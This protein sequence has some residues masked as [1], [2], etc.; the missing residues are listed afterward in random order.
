V[1][2]IVGVVV[3]IVGVVV[4]IVGVVVGVVVTI[5]GVVVGVV[6]TILGVVVTMVGVV[7]IG[8]KIN[9]NVILLLQEKKSKYF[10]IHKK[11]NTLELTYLVV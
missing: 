3:T 7:S 2:T 11:V 4:T 9:T 6:I 5:L 10:C 1:V 8:S